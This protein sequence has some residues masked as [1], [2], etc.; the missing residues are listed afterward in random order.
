M[1]FPQTYTLLYNLSTYSSTGRHVHVSVTW[2]LRCEWYAFVM[3]SEF[4]MH[5]NIL[6]LWDKDILQ[7]RQ[8]HANLHPRVVLAVQLG[9]PYPARYG[10]KYSILN[11]WLGLIKN[12]GMSLYSAVAH[13]FVV[14]GRGDSINASSND[15]PW[16]LTPFVPS[17]SPPQSS[18]EHWIKHKLIQYFEIN[19]FNILLNLSRKCFQ[20]SLSEF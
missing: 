14:E 12:I 15:C 19:I 18:L 4:G 7:R 17:P 8:H 10:C 6:R 5:R 13:N 3:G 20:K 11:S 1:V 16:T 9:Y 2:F